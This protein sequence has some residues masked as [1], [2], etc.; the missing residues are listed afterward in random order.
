MTQASSGRAAAWRGDGRGDGLDGLELEEVGVGELLGAADHV[1][2][3]VVEAGRDEAAGR[4]H[5]L[6]RGPATRGAPSSW[7]PIQAIRPSAMAIALLPATGRG[8][9]SEP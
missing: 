7:R 4:I 5:D 3:G 8:P 9:M 1:D 2:V 6:G